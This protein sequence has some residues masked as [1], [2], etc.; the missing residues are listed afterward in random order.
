MYG[1][2]SILRDGMKEKLF[3]AMFVSTSSGSAYTHR[4]GC[5]LAEL[6]CFFTVLWD[7]RKVWAEGC[8]TWPSYHDPILLLYRSICAQPTLGQGRMLNDSLYK[9]MF[10]FVLLIPFKHIIS[11]NNHMES[12]RKQTSEADNISVLILVQRIYLI[13]LEV[14]ENL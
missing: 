4:S 2:S 11:I 10:R 13:T 1:N 9:V 8:P 7:G 12:I 3:W 5:S 14:Y 6:E